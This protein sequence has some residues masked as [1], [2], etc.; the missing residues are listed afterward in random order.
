MQL[1][2]IYVIIC[3]FDFLLNKYGN[4]AMI[5]E[6]YSILVKNKWTKNW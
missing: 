1:K 5:E 4:D 6:L 2:N 3:C